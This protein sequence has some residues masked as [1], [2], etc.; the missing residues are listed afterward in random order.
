LIVSNLPPKEDRVLKREHIWTL[1]KHK[2][3]HD[4]Y[5]EP[6]SVIGAVKN[7]GNVLL[8][9]GTLVIVPMTL[10]S[11][12]QAEIERFAPWLKVLTLHT[13]ASVKQEEMASA[14]VVI[15]SSILLQR[16]GAHN[17]STRAKSKGSKPQATPRRTLHAVRRIHW[18]RIIVD[19]AHY[20]NVGTKFSLELASLSATH[21]LCVTGTPLGNTLEDLHAEL[22]FLRVPQFS[23]SKFFENAISGPFCERN[24]EALR[25]LRYILSHIVVRHSKEQEIDVCLPP[26]T[27][28]TEHIGFS[29]KEDTDLY[30]AIEKKSRESFER[31]RTESIA[32]LKNKT[33]EMKYLLLC[34]RQ[35]C[36]HPSMIDPVRMDRM[37]QRSDPKYRE[38]RKAAAEDS[39]DGGQQTR[40]EILSRAAA[41]ARPSAEA[42][43]RSIIMRFQEG[44]EY[45]LECPV[46]LDVCSE[47]SVAITPCGHITCTDCLLNIL[48]AASSRR[49]ASGN[50]PTCRDNV[51]RSEITFLGQATDAGKRNANDTDE[52]E[53]NDDSLETKVN[54]F[55]YKAAQHNVDVKGGGTLRTGFTESDL[56]RSRDALRDDAARLP[57]LPAQFL[58]DYDKAS[59]RIGPKIANLIQEIKAMEKKDPTTKAVV[60]SQFVPLLDIASQE[61]TARGIRFSR[62]YGSDK[63]HERADALLDF[64]SEPNIKVMLLSMK[65]GAVGK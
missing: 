30:N 23:R 44:V 13:D 19:E 56:V 51:K 62:I 38:M 18:H 59:G 7:N 5:I 14:D 20:A 37:N 1:E 27:V 34:A 25:I 16:P 49:E 54:G 35:A 32:T 58:S 6:H 46:C 3:D 39:V 29:T 47:L 4:E 36:S 11:Q 22:R 50:C 65:A 61:L 53:D 17:G 60:F 31:L 57:T 12:W 2:V 45:F 26:R 28:D 33:G 52:E 21:R 43:V 63:Q 24:A 55:Q 10:I 48:G 40:A 41:T 64:S 9:N 15:M 42:R 8:S